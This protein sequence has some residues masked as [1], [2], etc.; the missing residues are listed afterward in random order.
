MQTAL[1]LTGWRD[2]ANRQ[3]IAI[4][5]ASFHNSTDSK[6]IETI[7]RTSSNPYGSGTAPSDY[8]DVNDIISALQA[9][10]T[11]LSAVTLSSTNPAADNAPSTE[12]G[13]LASATGGEVLSLTGNYGANLSY[14]ASAAAEAAGG[15]GTDSDGVKWRDILRA[16]NGFSLGSAFITDTFIHTGPK[17]N[18]SVSIPLF[19]HTAKRLK[20]DTLDITTRENALYTRECMDIVIQKI[21]D[22]STMYGAYASRLEAAHENLTIAIENTVGSESTI[23]DADMARAMVWYTKN[24]LLLQASQSMLA[25]ANHASEGVLGL[26]Q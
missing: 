10:N 8:Q 26:L 23:R 16:D 25:Q 21:L 13:W 2:G 19:D 15:T 7:S 1:S 22:H 9:T 5:D 24:N 12:W 6:G 20:L 4:T 3:I 14:I 17:A 18:E 11:R